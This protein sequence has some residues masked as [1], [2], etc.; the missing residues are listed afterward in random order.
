MCMLTEKRCVLFRDKQTSLIMV[1]E[2]EVLRGIQQRGVYSHQCGAD[3]GLIMQVQLHS[4]L[5]LY[6][7]LCI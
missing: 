1:P 7:L 2:H 4:V 6:D 3:A 5:E